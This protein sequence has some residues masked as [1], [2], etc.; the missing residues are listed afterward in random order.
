[1]EV[2]VI[3]TVVPLA[4]SECHFDFILLWLLYLIHCCIPA[5]ISSWRTISYTWH[6][7]E[8]LTT[9]FWY[10]SACSGPHSA[11]LRSSKTHLAHCL[12]PVSSPR[13]KSPKSS[14][15][16]H[17]SQAMPPLPQANPSCN[18]LPIAS[19]RAF[20]E[21]P[22]SAAHT[23]IK[24][25]QNTARWGRNSMNFH[26]VGIS[27]TIYITFMTMPQPVG[28]IN[29]LHKAQIATDGRGSSALKGVTF[30]KP[31]PGSVIHN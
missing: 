22:I 20:T 13:Q 14:P 12:S 1:M 23:P 29:T 4:K 17:P 28:A 6:L 7:T 3:I 15:C 21:L 27:G 16:E 19:G 9:M 2:I 24:T 31:D 25:S 26:H 11:P 10:N 8:L 5:A 18:H 30:W